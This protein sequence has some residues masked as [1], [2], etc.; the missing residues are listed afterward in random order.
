ME[1][2]HLPYKKGTYEDYV[3]RAGYAG[4]D[5]LFDRSNP[6]LVRG[7]LIRRLGR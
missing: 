5:R 7:I 6:S 3:G 2:G 1:L 4:E